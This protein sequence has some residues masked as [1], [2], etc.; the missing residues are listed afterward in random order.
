LRFEPPSE[1]RYFAAQVSVS[2]MRPPVRTL[3]VHNVGTLSTVDTTH[4]G[5]SR[6][7]V[8]MDLDRMLSSQALC[9]QRYSF[10]RKEL[11]D[12]RR[13]VASDS[14]LRQSAQNIRA[15][16]SLGNQPSPVCS[17]F[18]QFVDEHFHC[19]LSETGTT[20]IPAA[21]R[22]KDVVHAARG[23]KRIVQ[24]DSNAGTEHGLQHDGSCA[25]SDVSGVDAR[26]LLPSRISRA[27]NVSDA[28]QGEVSPPNRP[29]S[30]PASAR[31]IV[32]LHASDTSF[33]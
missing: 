22:Q 32:L 26:T 31:I 19:I 7:G 21:S 28:N 13:V 18:H 5:F 33:A 30:L 29:V 16:K 23:E 11:A 20:L 25:G 27:R 12:K 14:G 15:A 10:G 17:V 8:E 1:Q 2:E 6:I 24:A 9:D 4:F 3:G